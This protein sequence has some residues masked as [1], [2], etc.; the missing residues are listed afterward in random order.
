MHGS[1]INDA[2]FILK[3]QCDLPVDFFLHETEK[4][5]Y[6]VFMKNSTSSAIQFLQLIIFSLKIDLMLNLN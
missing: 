3:W 1:L 4:N 5:N 6:L 2:I